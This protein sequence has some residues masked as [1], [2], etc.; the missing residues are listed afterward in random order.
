[1]R[2][3]D[4]A[5]IGRQITEHFTDFTEQTAVQKKPIENWPAKLGQMAV[6]QINAETPETNG[7]MKVTSLIINLCESMSLKLLLL[8]C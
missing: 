4:G 6:D 8:R 2:I 5:S 7:R 1:M 3:F